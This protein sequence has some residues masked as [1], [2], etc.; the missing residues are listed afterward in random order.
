VHAAGDMKTQFSSV[1]T[2]NDDRLLNAIADLL[3]CWIHHEGVWHEGWW[4]DYG[5]DEETAKEM[6]QAWRDKYEGS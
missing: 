1:K 3:E 2:M 6:K 4:G 5:I